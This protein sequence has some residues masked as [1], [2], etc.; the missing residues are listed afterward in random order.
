M[1]CRLHAELPTPYF[2]R[3]AFWQRNIREA[4]CEDTTGWE[5]AA[6]NPMEKREE[7]YESVAI[8]V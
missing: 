8:V 1:N 5:K 6:G 2:P 7:S 4:G 3:V